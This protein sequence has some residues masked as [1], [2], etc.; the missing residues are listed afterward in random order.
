MKT[1]AWILWSRASE[2][3]QNRVKTGRHAAMLLC[4]SHGGRC[5]RTGQYGKLADLFR[6]T[7]HTVP[8]EIPPHEKTA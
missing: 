4:R 6:H 3:V 5:N 2:K 8:Y 7:K 1:K